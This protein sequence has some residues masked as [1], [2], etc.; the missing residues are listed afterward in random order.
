M[1][2]AEYL[3]G[4]SEDLFNEI[5]IKY[6]IK[7]CRFAYFFLNSKEMAEETVQDFF[8]NLW[9]KRENIRIEGSLETYL[10]I[11]IRNAAYSKYKKKQRLVQT[12]QAYNSNESSNP[13]L[14]K[15]AFVRRL[16]DSLLKLPVKCRIVYSLKFLEGLT[17]EEIAQFLEL[18]VK[19]VETQIYRALKKLRKELAPYKLEFY[20]TDEL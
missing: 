4:I 5:Y 12:E 7:L 6:F 18:S 11:S 19:T 10:F 14:N 1:Q 2:K 13:I 16:N 8:S 15:E 9:Q 17:Y 3:A 20:N